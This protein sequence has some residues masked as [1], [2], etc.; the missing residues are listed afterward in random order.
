MVLNLKE[1]RGK[2]IVRN[3]NVWFNE[4]LFIWLFLFIFT[5]A[6]PS[7]AIVLVTYGSFGRVSS[8]FGDYLGAVIFTLFAEYT[9]CVF[10]FP[11]GGGDCII[12]PFF[13]SLV[14]V[15]LTPIVT[16]V[17]SHYKPSLTKPIIQLAKF[18]IRVIL[19]LI[20][21]AI[22]YNFWFIYTHN[23]KNVTWSQK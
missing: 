6:F 5:F 13:V 17:I 8:N 14:F 12:F 4:A 19:V 18:S 7:I 9:G 15:A 2:L 11:F 16:L 1:K 10:N 22:L 21:S 20:A 3:D 23:S